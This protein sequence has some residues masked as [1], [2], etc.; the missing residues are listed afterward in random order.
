MQSIL[1]NFNVETSGII[2]DVENISHSADLPF[3]TFTLNKR[4]HLYETAGW[5]WKQVSLSYTLSH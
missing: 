4:T 3:V 2:Y 5:N 1:I